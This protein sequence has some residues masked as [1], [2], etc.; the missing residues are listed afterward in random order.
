MTCPG[1]SSSLYD[2]LP[3]YGFRLFVEIYVG[4]D[5]WVVN[6]Q[7]RPEQMS[8]DDVD[9]FFQCLRQGPQLRIVEENTFDKSLEHMQFCSNLTW[10][11]LN[12]VNAA[13]ASEFLCLMSDS[14]SRRLAQNLAIFPCLL[15]F[16]LVLSLNESRS[17]GL[18]FYM[19]DRL[20]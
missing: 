2:N 9:I 5:F 19:T 14:V 13:Q 20:S 1:K 16:V 17:L 18:P 10:I 4:D 11:F 3:R 8:L 12:L 6:V 7:N 15:S